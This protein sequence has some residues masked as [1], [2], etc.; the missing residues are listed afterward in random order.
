MPVEFFAILT[1]AVLR[2]KENRVPKAAVIPLPSVDPN[3]KMPNATR[4]NHVI[5][6]LEEGKIPI[7]A[8][9]PPTIDSAIAMSGSPYDG[10]VFEAEHNPYDIGSLR[11][12]LQY[13]LNRKQIAEGGTLAP[14]VTPM[15]RIPA[16]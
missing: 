8:F 5:R 12:C 4:L 11:D 10:V 6:L 3:Q 14:A 16:N 7:T 15:I 2:F 13:M 9:S 1:G